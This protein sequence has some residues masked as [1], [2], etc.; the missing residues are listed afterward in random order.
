MDKHKSLIQSHI[1]YCLPIW[2]NA[3]QTHM[4][5]LEILQRKAIRVVTNS[6]YN[7]HTQ[8][9]FHKVK[10][11]TIKDLYTLRCAKIGLKIALN[12]ANDG[13]ASCFR[14]I[15]SNT[16]NTRSGEN[17]RLYV[18]HARIKMTQRMPQY[19]IPEIWNE[20]PENLKQYGV[21]ALSHDFN[22]YKMEEYSDF[23][24]KDKKCY[25]CS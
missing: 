6:K 21:N 2:G 12:K 10:S 1:E 18:P 24:C 20:L 25:A 23:E 16:T 8:P 15:T 19:Q 5:P 4:K 17:C 13:L 9:L 22:F 14:V 11:L 3:L 7:S